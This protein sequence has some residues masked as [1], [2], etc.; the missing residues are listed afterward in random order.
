MTQQSSLGFKSAG[1]L[2]AILGIL[3]AVGIALPLTIENPLSFT[4]CLDLLLH[5]AKAES[6]D[7]YY[8]AYGTLPRLAAAIFRGV[9]LGRVPGMGDFYRVKVPMSRR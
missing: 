6:F 1:A 7:A 4:D 9:I 2:I 5:P 3:F 8:Y